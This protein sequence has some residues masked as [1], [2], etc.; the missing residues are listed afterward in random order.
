MNETNTFG[1]EPTKRSV[2]VKLL[3][4]LGFIVTVVIIVWLIIMG[5]K[6][7]PALFSSLAGMARGIQNYHPVTEITLE[8]EKEVV[9]SGESFQISWTDVKQAGE[10]QFSY[11]CTDGISLEVRSGDGT[12]VPV[13]CTEVLTLPG[14]VHGLFLSVTSDAMRFTDVPLGVTFKNNENDAEIKGES[15]V[16]VVNATI[17]TTEQPVVVK[18][19]PV[20]P[21]VVSTPK[22]TTP[23]YVAPKPQAPII[24]YVY[25]ESD[26]KGYIDLKV[27]TLGSGILYGNTFTSI[28]DFDE[29][30]R[31][32]IKF[33]IKNIGTKTSGSW[34]FKTILPNGQTYTSKSQTALKPNE[35]VEFTMGFDLDD[36]TSNKVKITTTVDTKNDTNSKNDKSTWTVSVND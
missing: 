36:D 10:Y 8:L 12:L 9:N 1:G 35:H 19:E 14:D 28:S 18:P 20:K 4:I 30:L 6:Q 3:A 16:T 7:A 21:V 32:A 34:T 5:I 33:D 26:P 15:K 25:P 27:T 29:D 23:V 11:S 17:P 13:R 22:P 31:N 2:P 24:T